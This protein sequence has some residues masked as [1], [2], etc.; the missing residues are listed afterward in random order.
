MVGYLKGRSGQPGNP[1]QN[2]VDPGLDG[3]YPC[4]RFPYQ[5]QRSKKFDHL[6]GYNHQYRQEKVGGLIFSE[7]VLAH[8]AE[9]GI[10]YDLGEPDYAE[11]GPGGS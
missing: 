4:R 8:P 3:Q 7:A 2:Q 10:M 9:K 5:K 11:H 1:D 6:Q